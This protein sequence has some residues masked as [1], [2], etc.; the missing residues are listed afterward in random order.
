M[1]CS[2]ICLSTERAFHFLKLFKAF[3]SAQTNTVVYNTISGAVVFFPTSWEFEIIFKPAVHIPS[4]SDTE[5]PVF[6]NLLLVIS[7]LLS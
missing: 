3:K 4:P 5:L 7:N 2:R 1:F 6:T